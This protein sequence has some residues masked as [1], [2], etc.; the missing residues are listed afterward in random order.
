M[1]YNKANVVQHDFNTFYEHQYLNL[2]KKNKKKK[3]SFTI[4]QNSNSTAADKRSHILYATCYTVSK[5]VM[6]LH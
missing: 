1:S 2:V 4:K 3:C 5:F 6:A